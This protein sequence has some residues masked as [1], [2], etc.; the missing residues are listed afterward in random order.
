MASD[1]AD[2]LA[3]DKD[4]TTFSLMADFILAQRFV[5]AEKIY[6]NSEESQKMKQ[7]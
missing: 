4:F 2:H 1:L 6:K 7:Y 5:D 3:F